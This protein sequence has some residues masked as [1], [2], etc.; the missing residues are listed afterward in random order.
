MAASLAARL[1]SPVDWPAGARRTQIDASDRSLMPDLIDD[2]LSDSF[3][4]TSYP[5]VLV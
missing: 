1:Y 2:H 3:S 4:Y 5:H